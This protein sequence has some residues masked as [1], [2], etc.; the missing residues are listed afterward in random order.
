MTTMQ[1][2]FDPGAQ[3][4]HYDS[5][6]SELPGRNSE[7]NRGTIHQVVNQE[8]LGGHGILREDNL[9]IAKRLCRGGSS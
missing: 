2:Y 9:S 4:S 6:D 1:V 8:E 5:R 7:K 3:A